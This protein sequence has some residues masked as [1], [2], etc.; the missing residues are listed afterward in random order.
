M[1]VKKQKDD[2]CQTLFPSDRNQLVINE[3]R[4]FIT[5]FLF[6]VSIDLALVFLITV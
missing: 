6:G 1:M 5:V 4:L 2:I 3:P